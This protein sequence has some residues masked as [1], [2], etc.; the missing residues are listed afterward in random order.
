M[1]SYNN[2]N[3]MNKK[4][5]SSKI[6][7]CAFLLFLIGGYMFYTKSQKLSDEE[8]NNLINNLSGKWE[9][10]DF[11]VNSDD[12]VLIYNLSLIL[13]SDGTCVH[14]GG[15]KIEN[16]NNGGGALNVID[17]LCKYEIDSF[18]KKIKLVPVDNRESNYLFTKYTSFD[19]DNKSLTI[20]KYPYSRVE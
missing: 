14:K 9:V 10:V 2:V 3:E 18:G 1:N 12:Y 6:F 7:F 13:N 5:L 11:K 19:L 20:G 15:F 4:K 16:S 8:Y 17:Y